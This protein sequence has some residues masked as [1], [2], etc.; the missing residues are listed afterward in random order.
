[1]LNLGWVFYLDSSETSQ[2]R[3]PRLSWLNIRL[4]V[5]A[6]VVIS[7]FVG[8]SPTLDSVLTV[9]S[10]LGILCFSLSLKINK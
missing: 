9:W 3:A 1:M 10:L 2:K 8:S 4:F 7:Q 5:S 6:Q